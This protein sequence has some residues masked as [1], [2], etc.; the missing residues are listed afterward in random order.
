EEGGPLGDALEDTEPALA[1]RERFALLVDFVVLGGK[2]VLETSVR[3][4]IFPYVD[5]QIASGLL[6]I[7]DE[8]R[9]FVSPI[10]AKQ[11]RPDTVRFIRLLE[12]CPISSFNRKFPNDVGHSCGS[13]VDSPIAD[14]RSN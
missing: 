5:G 13:W 10:F 7:G 8:D 2:A 12:G 11:L 4:F 1:C 3:I 14:S 9:L 6:G